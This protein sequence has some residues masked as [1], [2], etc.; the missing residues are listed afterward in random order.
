MQSLRGRTP[1]VS[2]WWRCRWRAATGRLCVG[3]PR[4]HGRTRPRRRAALSG[5][6]A[7]P[8]V[9]AAL[10]VLRNKRRERQTVA[11]FSNTAPARPQ[12]SPGTGTDLLADARARH[13]H[14]MMQLRTRLNGRLS[15]ASGYARHCERAIRKR[16]ETG[17]LGAALRRLACAAAE[18]RRAQRAV[19]MVHDDLMRFREELAALATLAADSAADPKQVRA[20]RLRR[21]PASAGGSRGA[22]GAR[23]PQAAFKFVNLAERAKALQALVDHSLGHVNKHRVRPVEVSWSGMAEDVRVM[24]SFD[25]WTHGMPLTPEERASYTTFSATLQL[26]PGT[27]EI[28]MLVDGQWRVAA[29]WPQLGDGL[30]ANNLLTVGEDADEVSLKAEALKE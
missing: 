21:T 6:P 15:K 1:A 2:T 28:K 29:D 23:A 19:G 10:E 18:P 9:R 16:D 24:G 26:L 25:G 27:Y 20:A 5:A 4:A 17:A 30:E 3:T 22:L 14:D 8:Q 7:R 12:P 13:Q 11:L